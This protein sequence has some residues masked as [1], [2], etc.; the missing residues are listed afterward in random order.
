MLAGAGCLQALDSLFSEESASSALLPVVPP[1]RWND[2]FDDVA[3][4]ILAVIAAAGDPECAV[5]KV[6]YARISARV[7]QRGPWPRKR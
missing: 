3:G 2:L 5:P 6:R 1:M 4:D 7:A